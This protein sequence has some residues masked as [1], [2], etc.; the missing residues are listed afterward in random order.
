MSELSELQRWMADRLRARRDLG[1]DAATVAEARAHFT[2]NDRVA[3]VEQLEIYREQ[4]WLRHTASLVEDFPGLGGVLGQADWE[5]LVEEYLEAVAPTSFSL[6]DLGER[7]PAFVEA[8]AWLPHRELCHDMARLEWS[9]IEIF[10]APDAPP[11]DADRLAA[12]PDDAWEAARMRMNPALRLL[13]VDYPVADL[14]RALRA[15]NGPVPLPERRPQNLVL[16]RVD[17][18]LFDQAL[19]DAPF[20]LLEALDEG[21]SLGQAAERVVDASAPVSEWFADWGRLGWIVDV[22][23]E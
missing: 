7:L 14:R 11:L 4:F 19:D 1:G 22:E 12:I 18:N 16:Y 20:A 3:P 5:R 10:D 15:D 8:A 17:G 6:R 9:Y 21:L 23:L 13:R 2:G